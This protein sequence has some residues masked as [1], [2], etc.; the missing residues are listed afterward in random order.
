[1]GNTLFPQRTGYPLDVVGIDEANLFTLEPKEAGEMLDFLAWCRDESIAVFMAGLTHDF[2]HHNF[3]YIGAV[4]Q[5]VTQIPQKPVCMALDTDSGEKCQRAAMHTQ[6]VWSQEFAH[7][8]GL[9]AYLRAE[10]HFDFVDKQGKH[11]ADAYYPAPFFDK[12]LRIEEERD[13]RIKYLPVCTPCS[14]IPFKEEVFEI[15]DAITRG[16]ATYGFMGQP[17]LTTAVV[18]FLKSEKWVEQGPDTVLRP[19]PFYRN[20]IGSFSPG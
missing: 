1:M 10:P 4:L 6:R 3:G 11:F 19:V 20:R 9:E 13:G 2:R 17:E 5:Y 18:T 16:D 14:R 7:E 8:S 12:T 15:Y